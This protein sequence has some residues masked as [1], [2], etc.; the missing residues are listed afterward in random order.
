MKYWEPL[1][2][3]LN[4]AYKLHLQGSVANG[5]RLK[6]ELDQIQQSQ[7]SAWQLVLAILLTTD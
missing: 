7:T 6:P 3:R 4:S 5:V 1:I 2:A